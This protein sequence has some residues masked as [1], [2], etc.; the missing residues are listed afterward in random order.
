LH[1]GGFLKDH[2]HAI[3]QAHLFERLLPLQVI[4][5]VNL[6][7]V[8]DFFAPLVLLLQ[9]TEVALDLFLTLL[10]AHLDFSRLLF[11]LL[12]FLFLD[13][14]KAILWAQLVDRALDHS[15]EVL[16]NFNTL[17][18]NLCDLG[19]VGI[20]SLIVGLFLLFSF[21]GCLSIPLFSTLNGSVL[22]HPQLGLLRSD[23]LRERG[24]FIENLLNYI[25]LNGSCNYS[26]FIS[27]QR[28]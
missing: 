14:Q 19:H 6:V 3:L 9:V 18:L 11:H 15:S 20:D 13:L 1:T 22:L 25:F 5:L 4:L 26:G 7:Q 21:Y 12:F 27:F 16:F 10:D 23:F 24:F 17:D 2:L 8:F 28:H